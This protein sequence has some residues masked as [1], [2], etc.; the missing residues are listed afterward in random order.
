[1]N[2]ISILS[3][4]RYYLFGSDDNTSKTEQQLLPNEEIALVLCKNPKFYNSAGKNNTNTELIISSTSS[5]DQNNSET[6]LKIKVK[7]E[8]KSFDISV[9]KGK[10]HALK[11]YD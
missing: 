5:Q 9:S 8:P 3:H 10:K 4:F 11:K 6:F 2:F 7:N 1:M